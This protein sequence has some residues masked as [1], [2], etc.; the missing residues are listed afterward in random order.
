MYQPK[1]DPQYLPPWGW[2]EEKEGR[3]ERGRRGRGKKGEK[4]GG[5]RESNTE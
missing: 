5:G 2:G 3:G 4:K 1:F